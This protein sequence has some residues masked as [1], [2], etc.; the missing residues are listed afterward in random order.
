MKLNLAHFSIKKQV[1]I[2]FVAFAIIILGFGFF[3]YQTIKSYDESIRNIKGSVIRKLALIGEISLNTGVNQSDIL[4]FLYSDL[5]EEKQFRL[6]KLNE[7][8]E[9]NNLLFEQLISLIKEGETQQYLNYVLR[10]R[11]SYIKKIEEII[12]SPTPLQNSEQFKNEESET[13]FF[14]EE[15]F[16]AIQKLTTLVVNDAEYEITEAVEKV[17]RTRLMG[18]IAIAA[19]ILILLINSYFIL[20]IYKGLTRDYLA[21]K[22]ERLEKV[23][24]QDELEKLNQDLENKIADRTTELEDANREIS[25]YNSELKKLSLAKDKFISVISHDLRN[26]I[27]TILASS[28]ALIDINKNE[29]TDKE[30]LSQFARIINKASVKVMTQLNELV[31]WAKNKR[32]SKIFNPLKLNLWEA[33][34]E[35]LQLLEDLADQNDVKLENKVSSALFIN[36]DKIMF[37]SIIQNLV[38]NSIKFTPAS[39]IVTI[40]AKEMGEMVEIRIK[41]TGIGMSEEVKESLFKEK[42]PMSGEKSKKTGMGLELVKEFIEKHNGTITVESEL[43]KGSLFIFTIPRGDL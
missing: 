27:S 28:E 17:N 5:S 6:K 16:S 15:Y 35:S 18:N 20:K 9:Q 8:T 37:R 23:K 41:D 4:Q 36:A 10:V 32:V 3:N 11:K 43:G 1:I 2:L 39:G 30:E 38:T 25:L 19:V 13:R 26:P 34:N 24:A 21:L 29:K 12:A 31:E 33:I 7:K 14:F 40:D 22:I 42:L